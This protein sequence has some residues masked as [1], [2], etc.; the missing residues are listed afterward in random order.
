MVTKWEE[1]YSYCVN[2]DVTTQMERL[3]YVIYVENQ[4]I[5]IIPIYYKNNVFLTM[6]VY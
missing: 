6:S 2:E 4:F 3:T 5:K 1:D